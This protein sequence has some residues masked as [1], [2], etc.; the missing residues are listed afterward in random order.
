MIENTLISYIY[1][2]CARKS[3]NS[4]RSDSRLRRGL[5]EMQT[6]ADHKTIIF[7]T[8]S[9]RIFKVANMV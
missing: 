3:N 7:V 4:Q 8:T 1:A 6:M 9:N 2:E 5:P